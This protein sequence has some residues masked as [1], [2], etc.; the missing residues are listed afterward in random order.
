MH[1]PLT[2]PCGHTLSADHISIPT[3]A[4]IYIDPSLPEHEI[5][6]LQQRQQQQRLS[7]WSGVMCPIPGC[8]RYSPT[9]TTAKYRPT[10]V[11]DQDFSFEAH[12]S[13]GAERNGL[14]ASGV[15]YYPPA[16]IPPP[17]YSPNPAVETGSPLIDVNV[18]KIIRIVHREAARL[19]EETINTTTAL[20]KVELNDPQDEIML[21]DALESPCSDISGSSSTLG[22]APLKKQRNHLDLNPEHDESQRTDQYY[23]RSDPDPL[24]LLKKD[25]LSVLECDVCAMLLHEP[26]T[27]PCQHV[28]L[29]FQLR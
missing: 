10:Q 22:R 1:R 19:D 4:P 16:P 8:K 25:M 17:D 14:L 9:A 29:V 24:E 26:V 20:G 18:E 23:R 2:L 5:I 28:S 12:V 21:H 3:P 13:S 6:E 11:L 7:L 15:A 27:T